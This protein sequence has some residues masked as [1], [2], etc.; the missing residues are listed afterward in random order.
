[1]ELIYRTIIVFIA[2]YLFLRLTGKKAVAQMHTFDLL[3]IFVLTNIIS[4]PLEVN[5]VG[6][7]LTYAVIIVILYKIFV[8]L[9]LHNKLRWILY[10]SPTV[11]IRNGD[12]D[13]NGLK[14]VRMPVNELLSHLRVKGFSDTQNIAIALMEETGNISVIPMA[15]YRP[16]QPNDL[17]I[18]VKKEYLPIPLIMDRQIV[19]HNLKYLQLDQ[20]WLI[21]EVKKMGEKIENITLATFLENGTLFIDN[22]EINNPI[23]DPYYYNPG[24]DN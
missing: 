9:S 6:K 18:Q 11:L 7:S 23:S 8:R 13:R 4:T 15:E 17:N 20:S 10:E 14:K 5:N 12:I 2:G 22:H 19:Y 3:Y 21:N 1:M 16:V 24:R